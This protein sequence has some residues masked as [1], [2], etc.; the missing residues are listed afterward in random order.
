MDNRQMRRAKASA[1]K[2]QV[3][4]V[5]KTGEWGEWEDKSLDF[6]QKRMA[7]AFAF[8]ANNIYSVQVYNDNGQKVLGIRRHDQSANI[9]WS[10][11]QR[12]KDELFGKESFFV[13]CFPPK[14]K[15]IDQA[16]LFWLW[17]MIYNEHCFD[18]ESAIRLEEKLK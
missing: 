1:F 14:S 7:N 9:S 10:D 13:E 6:R 18:L 3:K 15:L 17:E 5:V 2:K 11:K 4:A 12:I 16:N 8:Y